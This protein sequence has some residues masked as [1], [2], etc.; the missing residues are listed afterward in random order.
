MNRLGKKLQHSPLAALIASMLAVQGASAQAPASL[1]AC[2]AITTP[3][4]RLACYDRL[5]T[6]APA[7]AAPATPA[8]VPPA[9][10]VSSATAPAAPAASAPAQPPKES[11]GLYSA[12]HPVVQTIPAVK[13][14]VISMGQSANGHQTFTLDGGQLWELDVADPLLVRGETV[15]IKRATLGSFLVTTSTGRVHRAHRLR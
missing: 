11:F 14:T 9:A 6:Q 12:E 4:D 10:T 8:K 1:N 3:S 5:A 2:A 13:G 7:P 15:S